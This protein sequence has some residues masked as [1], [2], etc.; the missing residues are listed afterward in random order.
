MP[1]LLL[2][3]DD[4]DI[5]PAQIRHVFPAPEYDVRHATTGIEGIERVRLEPPKSFS[6]TF[7]YRTSPASRC[8]GESVRSTPGFPSS[9]FP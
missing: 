4:L 8:S 5:L 3:D 2:I 7:V 9:S 6:S 1:H